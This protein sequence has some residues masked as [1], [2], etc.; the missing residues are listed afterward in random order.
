[1]GRLDLQAPVGAEPVLNYRLKD[2][3]RQLLGLKMPYFPGS[4]EWVPYAQH[5]KYLACDLLGTRALY[6]YL[7][8]RLEPAGQRYYCQ[9]VA[10]LIPALL[11]MT[12]VGVTAD[13]RFIDEESDRIEQLMQ[14]LS[15][16]H[17][18]TYGVAMGMDQEQLGRWLFG[19]L[20]LPVLKHGRRGTRWVP[21]LDAEAL[22]RLEAFN[23]DPHT[24]GSLR[25]IRDYRKAASLM[26]RL[27]SLAKYV[28]AGTGRIHSTFDDRQATGRLSS[29]YPNL[30]QLAKKRELAKTES[31]PGVEIRSRNALI[32]T[33]GYELAVFDIGQADIRVL[34]SM[35]ENFPVSAKAHLANLRKKR[36]AKLGP[37]IQ[38]LRQKLHKYRNPTFR[39]E[40][41]GCESKGIPSFK[42]LKVCGL[43]EDFRTPGDFYAKAV[44][45]ILDRPPRDKAERNWFKPIIL[46]IVNGK[47]A[48]SLARDLNCSVEEAKEYLDKF[49]KAYPEVAAY[50]AMLYD[51]IALT[52]RTRTFMGRTRTVTAH[53]WMVARKKVRILVTYKGGDRYW[54]EIVPVEPQLRV[55]T[56]Y[57]LRAWD[58]KT[59]RLIYDHKQGRLT[60]HPYR[61]FDQHGLQYRLPVRNW[62]WRSIRRV[63]SRGQE[64]HYEGFDATARAAFNFICQAGTADV[65]KLMMLRAGPLCERYGAR[66]LIQIHDELVFEVPREHAERF[67]TK[68]RREL[69]R[70]PTPEFRVPIVV[71]AKR[72]LRFGD[73]VEFPVPR[74]PGCWFTGL[75]AWLGRLVA[76]ARRLV[77][78]VWSILRPG[79]PASP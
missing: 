74:K 62:A 10:P 38:K 79:A 52:G 15:E 67:L 48:N 7:W 46:A 65:A 50:K 77:V 11:G 41:R 13:A 32:A 16:E 72:G 78:R 57:V 44:E 3:A 71:E 5:C 30:Q 75:R 1:M 35:V 21:S 2:V 53:R 23:E 20:G 28:D 47:G 9:L 73:L 56:S 24:A 43:A 63:R 33:Q 34:A 58:A 70:P 61:L 4:I 59:G 49:D 68:M 76:R 22:R 64:A 14:R 42:P 54:L 12:E 27:R 26:V 17:R 29:T 19:T 60:Q 55:L 37:T 39:S 69:E 6:E 36:L 45:R 66:L 51:Q 40:L 31:D 8:P 18:R 25:L